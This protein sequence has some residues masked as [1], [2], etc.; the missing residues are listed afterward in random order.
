VEAEQKTGFFYLT[1]WYRLRDGE[2]FPDAL[3]APGCETGYCHF[4]VLAADNR[5]FSITLC[6]SELDPL[7]HSPRDAEVFDRIAAVVPLTAPWIARGEGTSD[8]K[9]FANVHD[10]KRHL[11]DKKGPVVTGYVLVGDSALCTNPNLG[12]GASLGMVHA[13]HLASTITDATANPLAYAIDFHQWTVEHLGVWFELQASVDSHYL[14][15][16][17]AFFAAEAEASLPP[18]S[19]PAR[20]MCALAISAATD[21]R[22]AALFIK[23]ST[24]MIT[25]DEALAEPGV[26]EAIQPNLANAG[27]FFPPQ[28]F[29]RAEFERLAAL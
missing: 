5:T 8:P 1:R 29:P 10:R 7:R 21:P 19:Y 20:A 4:L 25:L 23:V 28:S 27:S 16:L 6:L 22:I 18:A 14:R 26:A 17:S 13:Q 2:E 15:R 3:G 12:R 9:P 11:V 24:V